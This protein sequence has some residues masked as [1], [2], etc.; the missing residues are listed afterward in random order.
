[1]WN[2]SSAG[3]PRIAFARSGSHIEAMHDPYPRALAAS[4]R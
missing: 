4:W 2:V 1:V 3:T